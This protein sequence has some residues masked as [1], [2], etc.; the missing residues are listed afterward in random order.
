MQK[1]GKVTKLENQAILQ[2]VKMNL[3]KLSVINLK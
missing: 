2:L 3:I 1:D